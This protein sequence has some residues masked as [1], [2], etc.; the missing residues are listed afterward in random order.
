MNIQ[1]FS[2]LQNLLIRR[3]GGVYNIRGILFQVHYTLWRVLLEFGK[4]A[5][6]E[7]MFQLEG[8]EDL[9]F[10]LDFQNEHIQVKCLDKNLDANGFGEDILPNLLEVF[11]QK[12]DSLFSIVTNS[13][14]AQGHLKKLQFANQGI[15]PLPKDSFTFWCDKIGKTKPDLDESSCRKFLSSISFFQKKEDTLL[16]DCRQMLIKQHNILN[17]NEDQYLRAL[18]YFLLVSSPIKMELRRSDVLQ[19]IQETT[20]AISKGAANLAVREGWIEQ[21]LFEALEDEALK[22]SFFEGKPARPHHIAA[23][24]PVN[25]PHWHQEITNSIKDFDVTVIKAASGQGKSTLAWKAAQQMLNLAGYFIFQLQELRR[26]GIQDV[27]RFLE[28]R[29]KCGYVPLIVIDGLNEQVRDWSDLAARAQKLRGVKFLVTSR[30]ED[31]FRYGTNIARLNLKPINIDL[32]EEEAQQIFHLFQKGGHLHPDINTWQPAWEKVKQQR[33]LLEYVFLLTQGKMIAER[34]GEQIAQFRHDRDEAAKKA[35]LRLVSVA[36]V[37]QI[38]LPAGKLLQFVQDKIGFQGDRGT[39]LTS[40]KNEY[41]VLLDDRPFVEGLHPVRSGHLSDLL[42]RNEGL[43]L[44]DTLIQLLSVIEAENLFAFMAQAPALLFHEQDRR[45][46]LAVLALHFS[47]RPYREIVEGIYGIYAYEAQMHWLQNRHI[48]DLVTDAGIELYVYTKVPFAGPELQFDVIE[49]L[50]PSFPKIKNTITDADLSLDK[51]NIGFFLQSL[52]RNI[53]ADSLRKDLTGL[54][55]LERWFNRFGLINAKLTNLLTVEHL[56]M[57]LETMQIG[58][59]G[60]LLYG[61]FLTNEA[62]YL[63]FFGQF[64][65]KLINKLQQK[66]DTLTIEPN[67]E[68]VEIRYIV[69]QQQNVN[70]QSVSRVETIAYCLPQFKQFSIVGLYFPNPFILHL[71]S[72]NDDSVKNARWEGWLK[73]DRFS[74]RGNQAWSNQ[75]LSNYQFSTQFEWQQHWF[76]FR[77]KAVE[78]VRQTTRCLE[79]VLQ[80]N[81]VFH[82]EEKI[83]QG[84][85]TSLLAFKKQGR[86][87]RYDEEFFTEEKFKDEVKKVEAWQTVFENVL[88]Q[89]F[90]NIGDDNLCRVY[91]INT[92]ETAVKLAAMQEAFEKVMLATGNYFKTD[93]LIRVERS[94]FQ[95]LAD[96]VE[97]FVDVW[98]LKRSKID[99]PRNE[100]RIW[101]E[102]KWRKE[103]GYLYQ[104]QAAFEDSLGYELL[105]PESFVEDGI[106]KTLVVGIQ[107]L[108]LQDFDSQ[109]YVILPFLSELRRSE[110]DFICLVPVVGS[111]TD[112]N[113]AIRFNREFFQQVEETLMGERTEFTITPIPIFLTS[114]ILKPLKGIYLQETNSQSEIKNH[115]IILHESLWRFSEIRKRLVQPDTEVTTWRNELLSEIEQKARLTLESL[116]NNLYFF[117]KYLPIVENVLAGNIEFG[118]EACSKYFEEDFRA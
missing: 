44:A 39:A 69:D 51:S 79:K 108:K 115:L 116:R 95:Y 59:L 24:L 86:R 87:I 34:L 109:L 70:Q 94:A 57:A 43:P 7:Q 92:R 10:Y 103:L 105:L 102:Q 48:Y 9:D 107:G 49:K 5:K 54:A 23:N 20:D 22:S 99:K 33:L 1:S 30:E 55:H 80:N 118:Q 93:D 61:V 113:M 19:I 111:N 66:T 96:L 47:Q 45:N 73:H 41:H 90:P 32:S 26:E 37:L 17:G 104:V 83:L 64:G 89:T 78:W 67:G 84:F 14:I 88:N 62:L 4:E 114:E 15:T 106:L 65:K 112:G 53:D 21:V 63:Q 74:V 11:E 36:D 52:H 58:Q 97:F 27:I 31:W 8:I 46:F 101:K 100:I 72:Q 25:R 50:N 68:E 98:R 77:K 117:Q 12:P 2:G 71:V 28:S 40:L 76:S 110:A 82:R 42:H 60:E 18:C 29:L 91:K 38:K 3:K 56:E 85:H 81:S 16:D 35:I 13:H 75:V 6:E